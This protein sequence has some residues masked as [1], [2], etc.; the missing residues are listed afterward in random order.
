MRSDD[1]IAK[2]VYVSAPAA[3][4]ETKIFVFVF[5]LKFRENIFSLFA[6][7]AYEKLRKF[8]R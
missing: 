4:V 8:S 5:S 1:S 6:K 7:K 3:R 2:F